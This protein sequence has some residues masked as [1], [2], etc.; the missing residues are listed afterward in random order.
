VPVIPELGKLRQE[1][2]EFQANLGYIATPFL[3]NKET[4]TERYITNGALLM[5]FEGMNSF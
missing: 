1:Y 5:G 4:I 2:P 3:Q